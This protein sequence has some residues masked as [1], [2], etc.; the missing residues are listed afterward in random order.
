MGYL[1]SKSLPN[2]VKNVF[3]KVVST[4]ILIL[5]LPILFILAEVIEISSLAYYNLV[6]ISIVTITFGL[7]IYGAIVAQGILQ[8]VLSIV[9]PVYGLYL[10]LL[11]V[12]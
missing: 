2:I 12:I 5:V 8:I 6:R 10:I 4:F 9:F 7:W 11:S 3:Y 1:S